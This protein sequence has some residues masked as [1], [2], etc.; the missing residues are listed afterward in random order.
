MARDVLGDLEERVVAL[1]TAVAAPAGSGGV[2]NPVPSTFAGDIYNTYTVLDANKAVQLTTTGVFHTNNAANLG[3]MILFM[4]PPV[5]AAAVADQ[6]GTYSTVDTPY[7][8][9]AIVPKGY[10]VYCTFSGSGGGHGSHVTT[11]QALA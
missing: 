10:L 1:E 4:K 9:K 6:V 5:G 2:A 7:S 3:S 8:L 11:V